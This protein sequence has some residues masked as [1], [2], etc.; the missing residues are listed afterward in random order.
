MSIRADVPLK[1]G[2][3][4]TRCPTCG[5]PVRIVYRDGKHA[6][7]YEPIIGHQAQKLV[8]LDEET[9][10]TLRK[11]RKGK[12][13]V[14]LVGMA[15]TSCSLAPYNESG[16]EVWSL[17]EAHA[18]EWLQSWDRWFQLHPESDFT[19]DLD[20]HRKFERGYVKG[21]YDWLQQEHDKPIYMLY[22]YDKVPDCQEYPLDKM[23][24]EF[25]GKVRKGDEKIKYF[26][27]TFAFMA[28]MAISEGFERIEIYGFEMAGGDEYVP[29]KACAEFW[30][31][32]AIGRGIEIYLP[33]KSQ[34]LWGP[35]YG[36]QGH[37]AANIV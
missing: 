5:Y 1:L 21:H 32:L 7:H 24:A 28:A 13:T 31:G 20:D 22:S 35:L 10:A 17:N 12:K 34:L 2:G 36:Y 26:T 19:R 18:F 29:Q 9:A 3:D 4:V 11:L 6:D 33:D 8:P 14:A 30:I 27:S 37:G 23:I 16:V 25:F 15:P